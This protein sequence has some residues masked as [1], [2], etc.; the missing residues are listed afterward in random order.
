TGEYSDTNIDIA[1]FAK[2]IE[3]VCNKFYADGYDVVSTIDVIEGNYS[4]D[5]GTGEAKAAYGY[6]YSVTDGVVIL[7]KNRSE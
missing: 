1:K 6:G 4:F 2:E 5:D 3:D 7:F